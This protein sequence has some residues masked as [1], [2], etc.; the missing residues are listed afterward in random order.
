MEKQTPFSARLWW[1]GSRG[2]QAHGVK[3]FQTGMSVCF[4]L[5]RRLQS[6]EA[7]G[8]SS[9]NILFWKVQCEKVKEM[10]MALG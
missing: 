10:K 5:E 8:F 9:L 2:P 3:Q 6:P 7:L 1:E 4:S